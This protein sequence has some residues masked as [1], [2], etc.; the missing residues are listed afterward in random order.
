MLALVGLRTR[1]VK[2]GAALMQGAAVEIVSAETDH[3]QIFASD[4]DRGLYT[5]DFPCPVFISSSRA[6]S[7]LTYH[8]GASSATRHAPRAPAGG[9][10]MG[11]RHH[12]LTG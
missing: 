5:R 3:M 11:H 8:F 10:P 4:S 12:S 1:G 9:A 2:L 7:S 6:V